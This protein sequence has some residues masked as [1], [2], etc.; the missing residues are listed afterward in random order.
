[1]VS[2]G[3]SCALNLLPAVLD[4]SRR[5]VFKPLEE[6][7]SLK[8]GDQS[9]RGVPRSSERGQARGAGVCQ[10][11]LEACE[12][13]GNNLAAGQENSRALRTLGA[14]DPWEEILLLC[15]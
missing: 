3:E 8:I 7:L 1:M 4:A 13:L 12:I 14:L 9:G 2:A 5:R 10:D 11:T 6:F 15:G